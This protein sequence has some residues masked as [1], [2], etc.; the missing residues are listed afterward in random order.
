MR[1]TDQIFDLDFAIP[2]SRITLT[3]RTLRLLNA[4]GMAFKALRNRL[5]TN[6]L[7]ELENHLLADIGL[8]REEIEEVRRTHGL[9][10]DPSPQLGQFARNRAERA[11]RRP[12]S[13]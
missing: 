10:Q 4:V 9:L 8:S 6:R 12:R 13:A 2:A 3:E 1:T 7:C 5:A 11:L